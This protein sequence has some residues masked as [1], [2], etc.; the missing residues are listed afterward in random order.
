MTNSAKVFGVE[1]RAPDQDSAYKI[2]MVIFRNLQDTLTG[3]RSGRWYPVPGNPAYELDTPMQ[4]R[5]KN[6]WIK[7][8]GTDERNE[9]VGSA[10]QASAPGEPPAVRTGRLRQS[11][12]MTVDPTSDENEGYTVKIRTTVKYADDLE[13]G[14]EIIDPRPYLAPTIEKS[15]PEIIRIL[16]NVSIK[17]VGGIR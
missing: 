10:Y 9:I 15:M 3:K 16:A 14:N 12:Y 2:G 8:Q 6:Y 17:I 5:A 1:F 4:L 11:F 7:Y 13:F